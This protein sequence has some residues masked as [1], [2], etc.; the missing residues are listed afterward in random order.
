M[1]TLS[2]APD[3]IA[4]N[5]PFDLPIE[6][7]PARDRVTLPKV[8]STKGPAATLAKI[9]AATGVEFRLLRA[10]RGLI[11]LVPLVILLSVLSVPWSRIAVEVSYSVA[12]ATS[13][14]NMLLLFLACAIVFYTGESMHRDRELRIEPVIWS[15]PAP[16]S[17]LLL[18]KWLAMTLVSLLLVLAGGLTTIVT[19][20]FRGYTPVDVLAYLIINGVVVVPGVVFMTSLVVA[21]NVLLRNKYLMYVVAIGAGAGLIYLYNHGHK[22]WSYNPLLYQLWTFSDLTSGTMLA[23]RLYCLALAAACLLLAHVL[24]ERRT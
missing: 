2:D 19:Q 8:T 17:V 22:H 18:S 23:Y 14:A 1:L 16:N 21:L 9:I 12:C 6:T 15:T 24:F 20:L 4:Y 5:A 3:R 13:T 7:A 10:E 11:V